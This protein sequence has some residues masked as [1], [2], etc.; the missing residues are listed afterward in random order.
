M[1]LG[2]R[3]GEQDADSTF[4][5]GKSHYFLKN[6]TKQNKQKILLK[7]ITS[8]CGLLAPSTLPLST[9]ALAGVGKNRRRT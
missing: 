8:D 2:E 4:S 3:E 7:E 9:P 5:G 6:N 1:L